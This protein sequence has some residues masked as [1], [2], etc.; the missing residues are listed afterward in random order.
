MRIATRAASGQ[1][2][3]PWGLQR[4]SDCLVRVLTSCEGIVLGGPR[5]HPRAGHRVRWTACATVDRV[6]C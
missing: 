6:S 5:V 1:G 4:L 2:N 3:P